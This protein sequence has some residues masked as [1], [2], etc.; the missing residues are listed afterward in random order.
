MLIS[1]ISNKF[2]GAHI[3]LRHTHIIHHVLTKCTYT[4]YILC[5]TRKLQLILA[6]V[7]EESCNDYTLIFRPS[8]SFRASQN[9]PYTSARMRGK[10][11]Q[12]LL[13]LV[14]AGKLFF[15]LPCLH[16]IACQDFFLLNHKMNLE[17]ILRMGYHW[18]TLA[19]GLASKESKNFFFEGNQS[20]S[21]PRLQWK[22]RS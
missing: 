2:Q 14:E 16:R 21:Y 8:E 3:I 1:T 22:W 17:T 6:S 12:K 7:C 9:R 4:V 5:I 18:S 15:H 11:C 13:L 10:Q 19:G 20:S